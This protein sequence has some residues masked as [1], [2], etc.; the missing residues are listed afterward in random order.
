MQKVAVVGLG[1]MGMPILRHIHSNLSLDAVGFDVREEMR[2]T[3]R[4]FGIDVVESIADLV[5]LVDGLIV[6]V[7]TDEQTKDVVTGVNGI[8]AQ[9]CLL[10]K[11]EFHLA[12]CSTVSISTIQEIHRDLPSNVKLSDIPLARAAHAAVDGTLLALFGGSEA[13]LDAWSPVLETFCT[14]IVRIG[15]LG[16]GQIAKTL[17]NF[18]LWA[19]V[20]ANA[21]AMQLGALYDCE[22]DG[23]KR[24]LLLSSGANWA[25]ET[26][27]RTRPMPWAEDD[28]RIFGELAE[29]VGSDAQFAEDV[30][31]HIARIKR[32]KADLG[33]TDQ[34]MAT[35][36][37]QTVS[38]IRSEKVDG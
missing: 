36:V 2:D 35:V 22:S 18:I 12:I 23:L 25:L 19:C 29:Q 5:D 3:A 24:A 10:A 34:S 20:C 26:W 16:T 14:D 9:E 27:D 31:R 21:E 17:N 6:L 13:E 33:L 1:A 32:E 8:L 30:G 38:R 4:A 28:M 11:D 7:G 37:E 15:K